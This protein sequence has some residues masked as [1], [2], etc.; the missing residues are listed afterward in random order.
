VDASNR[1][2]KQIFDVANSRISNEIGLDFGT[3]TVAGPFQASENVSRR[4]I[5]TFEELR[6]DL[7]VG[8]KLNFDW[9]FRLIKAT[10]GSGPGGWLETTYLDNG[11]RIGRGNKGTCFIL[12]R[13]LDAV[14]P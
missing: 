4:A 3:L 11:M 6:I 12:T 7:N 14:K 13:E 2:V 1:V 5:V 9:L 10:R 8:I